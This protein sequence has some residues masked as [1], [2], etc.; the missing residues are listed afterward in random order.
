[1]RTSGSD[2]VVDRIRPPRFDR[3][4][5]ATLQSGGYHWPAVTRNISLSG[6]LIVTG[7]PLKL[8]QHALALVR[9][10]GLGAISGSLRW[11][12]GTD[13]GVRFENPLPLR[14]F[15]RWLHQPQGAGTA[16]ARAEAP[17]RAAAR[18][19]PA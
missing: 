4:A 17:T 5:D 3:M 18:S 7:E 9:I 19:W 2:D 6:A 13:I 8:T 12:R 15:Q 1:L 11:L 16:D 10:D 14:H